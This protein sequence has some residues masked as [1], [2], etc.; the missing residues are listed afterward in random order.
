[1]LYDSAGGHGSPRYSGPP[2]VRPEWHLP[3]GVSQGLSLVHITFT[4]ADIFRFLIPVLPNRLGGCVHNSYWKLLFSFILSAKTTQGWNN[5]SGRPYTFSPSIYTVYLKASVTACL[6][7]LNMNF[8]T[9]LSV[10]FSRIFMPT[11]LIC[12]HSHLCPLPPALA[13]TPHLYSVP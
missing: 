9:D 6:H 8:L 5:S 4:K 11:S 12:Q 13:S 3:G 10:I 7:L 1:M 2:Q